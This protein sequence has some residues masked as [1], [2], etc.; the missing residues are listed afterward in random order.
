MRKSVLTRG[1]STEDRRIGRK[2]NINALLAKPRKVLPF[3]PV[4]A[5]IV[6]FVLTRDDVARYNGIVN[7][8]LRLWRDKYVSTNRAEDLLLKV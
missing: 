5:E 1:D 7:D 2:I 8:C 4:R 3:D 6:L